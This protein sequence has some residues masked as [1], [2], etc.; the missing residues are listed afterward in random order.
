[1][2]GCLFHFYQSNVPRGLVILLADAGWS[3]VDLFSH[4]LYYLSKSLETS[5]VEAEFMLRALDQGCKESTTTFM[6][7]LSF[8]RFGVL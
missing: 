3:F 5:M 8:S 1:M 7:C 4:D 2:S 6:S